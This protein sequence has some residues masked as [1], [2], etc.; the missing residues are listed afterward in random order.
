LPVGTQ[1]RMY[2][3]SAGRGVVVIAYRST[4]P[5]SDLAQRATW[6]GFENALRASELPGLILID[7]A[8]GPLGGRFACGTVDVRTMCLAT[9][10]AV[11]LA[12][13][14]AKEPEDSVASVRAEIEHQAG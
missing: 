8:P 9:D 12:I 1:F 14:G 5:Q 4:A 10:S 13:V 2:T 6:A 3:D 11:T 7:R